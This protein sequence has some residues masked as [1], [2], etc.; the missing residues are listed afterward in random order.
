MSEQAMTRREWVCVGIGAL[1]RSKK[2]GVVFRDAL[3]DGTLGPEHVYERT[4]ALFSAHVGNVYSIEAADTSANLSSLQYLRRWPDDQEVAMW[5]A[6]AEA[7]KS[8]LKRKRMLR[9]SKFSRLAEQL[10]PIRHTYARLPFDD[11]LAMEVAILGYL[12]SGRL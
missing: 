2:T 1:D 8:E 11:R 12:R 5:Q 9:D 10:E 4:K 6:K 7:F 3:S